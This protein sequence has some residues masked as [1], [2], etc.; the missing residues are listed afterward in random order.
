MLDQYLLKGPSAKVPGVLVI[1]VAA[2]TA[3]AQG[4]LQTNDLIT[5]VNQEPV[6]DAAVYKKVLEDAV[7]KN[8]GKVINLLVYREDQQ[9]A[10]SIQVPAK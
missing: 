5:H 8:L 9:T 3:A 1:F 4:N 6:S 2:N 10:I 7:A